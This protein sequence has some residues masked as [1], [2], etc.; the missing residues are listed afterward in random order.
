[1]ILEAAKY[2]SDMAAS[3]DSSHTDAEITLALVAD[4]LCHTFD[5]DRYGKVAWHRVAPHQPTLSFLYRGNKIFMPS[6]VPF[7]NCCD[8]SRCH[9]NLVTFLHNPTRQTRMHAATRPLFLIRGV[10]N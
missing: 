6:F 4:R 1:M 3:S 9:I 5:I 10:D 8:P 7:L 2:P